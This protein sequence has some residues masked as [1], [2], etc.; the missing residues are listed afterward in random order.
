MNQAESVLLWAVVAAVAGVVLTALG[1]VLWLIDRRFEDDPEQRA[2]SKLMKVGLGVILGA[3][4]VVGAAAL[5][6]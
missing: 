5:A 4:V 3:G 6:S 2:G 1:W